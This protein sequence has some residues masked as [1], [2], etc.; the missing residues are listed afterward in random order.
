MTADFTSKIAASLMTEDEDLMMMGY[1]M[2]HQKATEKEIM[3]TLAKIIKK[4][5]G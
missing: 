4:S 5:I 3:N 2:N 1:L